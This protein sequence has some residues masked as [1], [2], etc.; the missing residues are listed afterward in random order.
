MGVNA[1]ESGEE[2]IAAKPRRLRWLQ[3]QLTSLL[4]ML[5]VVA[6]WVQWFSMHRQIQQ[7]E[8]EVPQ[9]QQLC[10]SLV[11]VDS[12][13][14]YLFKTP[15]SFEEDNT[16]QIHIPQG[17]KRNLTLG[18]QWRVLDHFP[19]DCSDAKTLL[20]GEG[21]HRIRLT[22]KTSPSDLAWVVQLEGDVVFEKKIETK[23]GEPGWVGYEP[24]LSVPLVLGEGVAK[25]FFHR[26][27]K[28]PNPTITTVPSQIATDDSADAQGIILLLS[29]AR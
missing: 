9:L 19:K 12:S 4:M 17:Q 15:S 22:R 14:C 18:G 13:Q 21:T 8:K 3:L 7:L 6:I 23:N 24:D 25:R 26:E 10:D 16:W 11:P 5:A 2:E 1:E 28:D 20:L 29:E 27:M